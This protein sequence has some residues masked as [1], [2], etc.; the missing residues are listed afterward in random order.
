[1]GRGAGDGSPGPVDTESAAR[2]AEA[3]RRAAIDRLLAQA[4]AQR[5][6]PPP[7]PAPPPGPSFEDL[8][9]QGKTAAQDRLLNEL[10]GRG[11]SADQVTPLIQSELDRIASTIPQ[12]D[13]NIDKFFG[14]QDLADTI[15][16]R[17]NQRLR[18]LY[19]NQL[20]QTFSPGFADSLLAPTA[21]DPIIDEILGNQYNQALQ[22]LQAEQ[23][24]GVLNDVGFNAALQ[25]LNAQREANRAKLQDIGGGFLAQ[26]R[27]ELSDFG[28][29]ALDTARSV[30]FG[31]SFDPNVYTSG[32][33]QR[34]QDILGGLRGK[35][36]SAAGSLFD[37][38]SAINKG[39]AIQGPQNT[40]A[41][42][43]ANRD[44]EREKSR[45][46]GST[47]VF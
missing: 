13:T 40:V 9:L 37:T 4:R 12:G 16:G 1:M 46:L 32:L 23:S 34:T 31:Q 17:E 8:L 41:A 21:D 24:R 38:Q 6:A 14:G 11:F 43:L 18:D 44:K 28:N 47:G 35:L 15:I 30:Q 22:R 19:S 26:G 36:T 10:T 29:K 45:G 2:R 5:N 20:S 25:S 42:A 27:Q 3:E 7:A 33:D 39:G